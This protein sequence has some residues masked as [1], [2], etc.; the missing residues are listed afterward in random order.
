MKRRI[1]M[2]LAIIAVMMLAGCGTTQINL[3]KYISIE[4]NGYDSMGV[5]TYSFD[6]DAFEKDYSDKITIDK[7]FNIPKKMEDLSDCE[8]LFASCISGKLSKSDKLDNG[9]K[10]TYKWKCSD[11]KAKE[12]FNSELIYSDIEY[13]VK[14]LTEMKKFN[15][16]DHVS[17][18]YTGVE[19]IAEAA[20]KID[21]T[22]PEMKYFSVTL[23]KTSGLSNNDIVVANASLLIEKEEFIEKY[24]YLPETGE[25]QFTV[26]GIPTYVEGTAEIDSDT[27]SIMKAQA[28]DIINSKTASWASRSHLDSV[29][30]IGNI[31]ILLK[32]FDPEAKH[33]NEMDLVYRINA[34]MDQYE[35]DPVYVTY[36]YVVGFP[37]ISKSVEGRVNVDTYNYY[38]TQQMFTVK[39][40][41][42]QY[43]YTGD[44]IYEKFYFVGYPQ[45]EE[46]KKGWLIS[47]ME[48]FF[49]EDNIVE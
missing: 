7:S 11:D 4:V 47:N 5:A 22:Y 19:P 37:N 26:S 14:G 3:N 9:D 13:E 8:I 39:C 16:L 28:E 33:N 1:I 17:I 42:G 29:E 31:F 35:D 46:L 44:Y 32:Q 21:N 40:R 24:D 10:I 45:L 25:K 48:K 6:M 41:T 43:S 34:H 2:I 12:Y 36:Y 20:V 23:D 15:P 27:L 18:E 30:Y 38:D 49:V